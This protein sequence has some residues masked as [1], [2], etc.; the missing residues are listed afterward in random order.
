MFI[1]LKRLRVNDRS[2]GVEVE[3]VSMIQG[4]K[5]VITF[6]EGDDDVFCYVSDRLQKDMGRMRIMGTDYLAYEMIDAVVDQY[7]E[8]LEKLDIRIESLDQEVL[9]KPNPENLQKLHRIKRDT[10]IIRSS[11]WPLREV[12]HHLQHSESSLMT[13]ATSVYYRDVYDHIV[14]VIESIEISRDILGGMLDVYLTS[15]SNRMNETMKVLTVIATI[16]IPLTFLTGIFGMNFR[17]M[18][19]IESEWGVQIVIVL[20]VLLAGGMFHLFQKK[21]MDL[22][23]FPPLLHPHLQGHLH[24]ICVNSLRKIIGRLP[25]AESLLQHLDLQPGLSILD[26]MCGD[27]IPA[28]YLAHRVGPTGQ[29]TAIDLYE[30]QLNRARAFQGPH[31]PWLTFQVGDVRHLPSDF[32]PFD[33]ITGNLSFMF[34]RP[35]RREALQQVSQVLKPGGQLVL[36]FPSLGT[37]DSL[38]EHI[39]QKMKQLGLTQ[40]R[41]A[42]SDYINE[43]PSAEEARQWLKDSRME[44]H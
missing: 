13:K 9:E 20:M 41:Q 33:R 22:T 3:Q 12:I 1:V 11:I 31:F 44:K 8:I 27:G 32:G 28:F 14:A 43:R 19:I 16:F 17:Y 38:W 5:Y 40:E 4:Q 34:F 24:P 6:Q 18:P 36:T 42:L 39:D 10:I 23:C 37:F 21:E 7:F 15:L 29:V 35:H 26:I 30:P 25:F 2:K